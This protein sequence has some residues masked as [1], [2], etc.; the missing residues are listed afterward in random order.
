MQPAPPTS[1]NL[2]QAP[3]SHKIQSCPFWLKIGTYSI[4]EVLFLN[5]DLNLWNSGPKICFWANF[6]RK[7]QS[8][9]FCPKIGIHGIW[10]MLLS[11]PTLV[12][13]ISNPKSIF[14]QTWLDSKYKNK[15][16]R[17]SDH[18]GCYPFSKFKSLYCKISVY[19]L[20]IV[21]MLNGQS[22]MQWFICSLDLVSKFGW[23]KTFLI[24][25]I[26]IATIIPF[27]QHYFVDCF[28][29]YF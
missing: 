10:W 3:P 28:S 8:C 15:Q 12:F 4:L 13:W 29:F 22:I 24:R 2:Y 23:S 27:I 1:I 11:I 17:T 26:L 5:L 19:M 9:L 7:S 6:S 18:Q 25:K 21:Y 16:T 14:G 20:I